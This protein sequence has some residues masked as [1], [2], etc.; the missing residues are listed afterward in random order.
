MP[1]SGL[2]SLPARLASPAPYQPERDPQHQGAENRPPGRPQELV[3]PGE[4]PS[5][6]SACDGEHGTPD[7]CAN[8]VGEKKKSDVH[9]GHAGGDGDQAAN[10]RQ[11]LSEGNVEEAVAGEPIRCAVEIFSAEEHP[12]AIALDPP[13][14]ALFA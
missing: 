9:S 4:I 6:H 13:P 5:Q 3:N 1:G 7:Q 2:A 11:E 14:Q 12:F 8:E 10:P